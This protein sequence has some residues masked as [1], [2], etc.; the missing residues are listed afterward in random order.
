MPRKLRELRA[1]LRRAGFVLAYT[2]GSHETWRHPSGAKL[3]LAGKDGADAKPYQ[4]RQLRA[5]ITAVSA[6][7]PQPEE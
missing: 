1:E 5:M 3:T 7:P 4:E 6:V 2:T